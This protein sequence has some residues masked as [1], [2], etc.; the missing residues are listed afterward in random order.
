MINGRFNEITGDI[1]LMIAAMVG[2]PAFWPAV[3][4]RKRIGRLQIA[5]RLLRGE[6]FRN[7]ILERCVHWLLRFDDFGSPRES[8][9]SARHMDST[10]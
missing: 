10:V 8:T 9:M 1:S 4:I 3:A 5:V 6:N 2:R 7:P